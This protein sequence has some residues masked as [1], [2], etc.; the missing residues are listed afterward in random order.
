MYTPSEFPVFPWA[1]LPKELNLMI[2][3]QLP[4]NGLLAMRATSK[5][6]NELITPLMFRFGT[7]LE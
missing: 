7:S 3:Q 6:F 5:T 1:A 4:I 2:F